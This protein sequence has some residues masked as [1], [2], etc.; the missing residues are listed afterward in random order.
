MDLSNMGR[1]E[2]L[3][4]LGDLNQL[5][6]EREA[7]IETLLE[8]NVSLHQQLQSAQSLADKDNDNVALGTFADAMV[9]VE[10]IVAATQRAADEYMNEVR[11]R[12]EAQERQAQVLMTSAQEQAESMVISAQEHQEQILQGARKLLKQLNALVDPAQAQTV[13]IGV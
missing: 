3:K 2:L 12:C 1:L 4:E 8:K 11:R 10:Q 13:D 9:A 5:V 6:I 7:E